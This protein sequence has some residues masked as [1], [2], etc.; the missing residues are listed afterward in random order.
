MNLKEPLT[1]KKLKH[2]KKIWFP[3]IKMFPKVFYLG[4]GL[5]DIYYK[6]L[7]VFQR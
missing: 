2:L 7:H 4:H 6:D 3:T 1:L 5:V